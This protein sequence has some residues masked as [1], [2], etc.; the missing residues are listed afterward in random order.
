MKAE[1]LNNKIVITGNLPN[2]IIYK[3]RQLRNVKRSS[4]FGHWSLPVSNNNISYLEGLGFCLEGIKEHT[5]KH[6]NE[7]IKKFP[8]LFDYQ[9]D[10][11][12]KGIIT[13][14]F[15]IADDCGLGKCVCK[16]S[17]VYI[18]DKIMKIKDIH[19]EFSKNERKVDNGFWSVP[20]KDI[21]INSLDKRKIIRKKVAKIYREYIKSNVHKVTLRDGRI[22]YK[23]KPHKL[24]NEK[25][26]WKQKPEKFI[27]VPSILPE[28]RKKLDINFVKLLA[29]QIAEGHEKSNESTITITQKLR[30]DSK[31]DI[32]EE[33]REI[34]IKIS[35]EY[36]KSFNN[37]SN[38]AKSLNE[39]AFSIEQKSACMI[40]QVLAIK[41]SMNNTDLIEIIDYCKNL[42]KDIIDE[43][44]SNF[45]F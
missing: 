31:T 5:D 12:L 40:L 7:I 45:I 20:S 43:I 1:I 26:Q 9:I 22:L 3:I 36:N 13:G 33:L 25:L 27:C 24:L 11:V 29:W 38:S 30:G 8:F 17:E 2:K 23:T 19:K 32:L 4:L 21:Y 35:K 34:L 18:N 15:L 14:N 6:Y 16:N 44:P 42:I 41:S 39:T 37:M 28:G 10:A